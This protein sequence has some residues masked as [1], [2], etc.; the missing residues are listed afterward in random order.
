MLELSCDQLVHGGAAQT[1]PTLVC[2]DESAMD[3]VTSL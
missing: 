2:F 1:D 3:A